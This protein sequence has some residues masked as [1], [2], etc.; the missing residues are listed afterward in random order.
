MS[1]IEVKSLKKMYKYRIKRSGIDKEKIINFIEEY[2]E[3]DSK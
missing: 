3:G 1:L 2:L